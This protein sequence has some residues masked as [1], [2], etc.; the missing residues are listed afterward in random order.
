M[1]FLDTIKY[2]FTNMVKEYDPEYNGE[3]LTI[4]DL[5]RNPK[6]PYRVYQTECLYLKN[7][8]S[9]KF[10]KFFDEADVVYDFSKK[11]QE[12]Y[13]NSVHLPFKV[14]SVPDIKGKNTIVFFGSITPRREKLLDKVKN[15]GIEIDIVNGHYGENLDRLLED[16]KY[17]LSYGAYDNLV[18]DGFRVPLAIENGCI[19]FLE[20]TEQWY[21]E[22]LNKLCP[23]RVEFYDEE[24]IIKK[25]KRIL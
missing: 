21:Y 17:V 6:K 22:Y 19:V 7:K 12:Y 14:E 8:L 20:H 15:N 24:N 11:N 9:K 10:I 25:I 2:R 5:R 16:Y 23:D 18:C 13:P 1:G 4:D 3:I